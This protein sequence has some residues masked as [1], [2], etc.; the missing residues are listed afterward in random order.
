MILY[1]DTQDEMLDSD[2]MQTDSDVNAGKRIV[3]HLH[4][5]VDGTSSSVLG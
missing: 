4:P 3:Y 1:G 5:E 2:T